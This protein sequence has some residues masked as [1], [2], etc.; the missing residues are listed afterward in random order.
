MS[1]IFASKNL[2]FEAE[3]EIS[4]AFIDSSV[5]LGIAQTAL[6]VQDN[7]TECFGKLQCDGII[8]REKFNAF[9]VFTK[10]KIHFEERANWRDIVTVRTF[11]INNAGMRTNVN[12]E[13]IDKNGRRIISA[14]QEACVLSLENHRPLKLTTLPYPSENF[15]PAIFSEMFEKFIQDF[16]ED[17]FSFEQVIRSSHIDMS[18]H[19][20]N[21]EYIKLALCVFSD[22]FL[23]QNKVT[24][25]EVHFLGESK[26]G[27][28]LRVYKRFVENKFFIHIKEGSRSVFE[29]C[30]KF[31]EPLKDI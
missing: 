3:R 5:K 12:T 24:D 20:N 21:I 10:T 18:H 28:V 29:C 27:Q 8:Y 4:S 14:N 22:N 13:V 17:D 19:M 7:L 2:V 31:A 6:L 25:L 23:Q 16:S 26:E 11:P 9:W 1:D 30:V 15:P